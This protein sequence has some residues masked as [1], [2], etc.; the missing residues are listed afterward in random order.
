VIQPTRRDILVGLLGTSALPLAAQA[1]RC[2]R[3][4]SGEIVGGDVALGH[5]LREGLPTGLP[6]N[7]Q[8]V[9]PVVIVG[10]GIAGLAAAWR[11]AADGRLPFRLLELER[12]PGGTSRSG[13]HAI[14]PFPWA[15]HYVPVPGPD[16]P[17]L[18]R[19]LTDMDV[20]DPELTARAG[21]PVGREGDLVTEPEE[22][23]FYQGAWHSGLLP[24]AAMSPDDT[25][26]LHRF[27]QAMQGW[28]A[29]KDAGGT[30]PFT[31]PIA[32]AGAD[33]DAIALDRM[34]MAEW[35]DA[36]GIHSPRVRW[37]VDYACRDD[38]GCD[39]FHTSAWAGVFYYAARLSSPE[40]ESASFLTW[41]EGNGRIVRHLLSRIGAA[42]RVEQCVVDVNASED[43]VDLTVLDGATRRPHRLRTRRVVLA[44]PRFL[45]GK[46]VRP[47]RQAPPVHV[48]AFETS[49]WLVANIVLRQRPRNVGFVPAWDNVLY[50]SPSLGYVVATHQQ[51]RS[52]GP[53]LWTYYYAL[54][55]ADPRRA[56]EKLLSASREEWVDVILTDLSRAHPDIWDL[57]DRV[58]L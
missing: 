23:V 41:P 38:Y 2:R 32:H 7:A 24:L 56:R 28:A 44:V 34:S 54:A 35:L 39:L 37:F 20:L 43:G 26:Q 10:A 3:I 9:E 11:L 27:E 16:N 48:T 33:P 31:L 21:F 40:A 1:C 30:R 52:F 22:R 14:T 29:R 5:V 18:V 6:T 58:D 46:L 50:D 15:A 45:V 13:R 8:R 47:W 19:L 49:P 53:T 51:G 17:L 4:P 42:P 36:M 57:V 55:D 25:A 12:E